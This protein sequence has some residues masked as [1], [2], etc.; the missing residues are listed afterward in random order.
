MTLTD[1][2]KQEMRE[3][4]ERGREILERTE[5][6]TREQIAGLHGTIRSFQTLRQADP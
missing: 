2:E 3:S 1:E 4:D 5:S 6:L